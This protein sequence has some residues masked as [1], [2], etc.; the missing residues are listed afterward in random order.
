MQGSIS[1]EFL[2][3]L[4]AG[5][6]EAYAALYDRFGAALYRTALGM[7]GKEE[8][9]E[10]AVQEVFLSLVR[11]RSRLRGVENLRA[12]LF[13]ALRRAS[14]RQAS[15][16][17]RERTGS[18]EALSSA[19][20]RA[21]PPSASEGLSDRLE[22]ALRALPADQREVLSLKIQGDLTFQEIAV[23]LDV[24]IHTAAS[25]YRYALERLRTS[26]KETK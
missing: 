24:S 14:F 16:G 6:E 5:R 7:L 12:Y 13:A 15:R 11:S 23:V 10:D 3:G 1:E 2:A 26:L 4:A 8:D 9:A 18:A 25:R 21:D 17:G 20:S 22:R 19:P